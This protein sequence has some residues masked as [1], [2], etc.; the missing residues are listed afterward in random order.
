MKQFVTLSKQRYF[1]FYFQFYFPWKTWYFDFMVVDRA[2][3]IVVVDDDDGI[4]A[5]LSEFLNSQGYRTTVASTPNDL[6]ATLEKGPVDLITLDL[7]LPGEDGFSIAKKVQKTRDIPIIMVT[8]KGDVFDRVVGLELGADDY[9]A[10][11]F[12]LREVLARIRAVLRRNGAAHNDQKAPT[13]NQPTQNDET[14]T[15]AG[16]TIDLAKRDLSAPDGTPVNLTTGEF[17][18]LSLLVAHPNRVLSREKIMDHLKG[19]DWTPYDRS[20]D[21]QILR[22]RKKLET[23]PD[24]PMLIKTV[25]GAGYM[26]AAEVE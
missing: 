13:S 1:S 19:D 8:G 21:T 4:S 26:L 24:G 6:W 17:N 22:L 10:K 3:H 14:K 23:E 18:L 25:R 11:P 20:I 16:W 7:E 15:F 12:H 9:I 5:L 2:Q